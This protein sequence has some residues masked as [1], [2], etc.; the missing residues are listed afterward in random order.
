MVE[1]D[2][3]LPVGGSKGGALTGKGHRAFFEVMSIVYILIVRVVTCVY[4]F[5]KIH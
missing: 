3:G 1:A 2:Q 4:K 5:V